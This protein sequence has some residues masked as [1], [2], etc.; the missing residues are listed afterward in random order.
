[1]PPI[2]PHRL[3]EK[4]KK[5]DTYGTRLRYY[6][7]E[8]RVVCIFS[9]VWKLFN[10]LEPKSRNDERFR[11]TCY[12]ICGTIKQYTEVSLLLKHVALTNKTKH[13]T[14]EIQAASLCSDNKPKTN[15]LQM[16]L[17]LYYYGSYAHVPLIPSK[18]YNKQ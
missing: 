16:F 5:H 17:F 6:C 14:N 8:R 18:L 3:G 9:R 7:Y 2:L 13:S 15:L 1:M 4:Y 12:T 10:F 11:G